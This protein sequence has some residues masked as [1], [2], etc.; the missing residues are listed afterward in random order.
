MEKNVQPSK[1]LADSIRSE[2]NRV[3]AERIAENAIKSKPKASPPG[4]NY[5]SP[6]QKGFGGARGYGSSGPGSIGI[7]NSSGSKKKRKQKM[8]P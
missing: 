6:P 8:V 4:R 5:K 2:A 1:A 7:G 3:K